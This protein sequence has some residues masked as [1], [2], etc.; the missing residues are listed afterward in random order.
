LMAGLGRRFFPPLLALNWRG[1]FSEI[2]AP[3]GQPDRKTF[4]M[5]HRSHMEAYRSLA[6]ALGLS[7]AH[8]LELAA[9]DE[10]DI[11]VRAIVPRTPRHIRNHLLERRRRSWQQQEAATQSYEPSG[12]TGRQALIRTLGKR[13]IA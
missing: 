1:L 5:T 4:A 10:L 6:E 3:N 7:L 12:L 13:H 8:V 2:T 11:A 9:A